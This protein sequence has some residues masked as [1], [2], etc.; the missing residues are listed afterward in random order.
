MAAQRLEGSRASVPPFG[1]GAR[2]G[3]SDELPP[4]LTLC[5]ATPGQQL[6]RVGLTGPRAVRM[7]DRR[8]LWSL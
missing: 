7:P 5:T 1:P 3:V 2:G 4:P 8:T 6:R